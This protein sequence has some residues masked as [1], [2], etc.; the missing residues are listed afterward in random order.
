MSHLMGDAMPVQK[1]TIVSR[2]DA[3]G[4]TFNVPSEDRYLHTREELIDRLTIYL[5]GRAAEQVV[6]GRVTNGAANDLERTTAIARSMV[7]EWGMGD[8]VT[9]RTMRADNYALSEETKRVRDD[10]QA[11]ITDQAY[12]SAVTLLRKHRATLDRLASALLEHETLQRDEI[13]EV[14]GDVAP[15]SRSSETVGTVAVLPASSPESGA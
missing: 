3:L 11:R 7:F 10:A 13:A 4:Y 6:F 9:S 8:E 2:G 1:V 12:D 15:E 14:I 5:A